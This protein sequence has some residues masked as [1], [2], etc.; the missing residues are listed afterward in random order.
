MFSR[1]IVLNL[2]YNRHFL[3]EK[4]HTSILAPTFS[5]DVN[6][7]AM[8]FAVYLGTS[9][10]DIGSVATFLG[11]NGGSGFGKIFHR[12]SRKII[13]QIMSIYNQI[14]KDVRAKKDRKT[15]KAWRIRDEQT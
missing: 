8:L 10:Y 9:W 1:V 12:G 7:R 6:L 3:K 2:H 13:N 4:Q 15:V 5:Y 11:C 14:I